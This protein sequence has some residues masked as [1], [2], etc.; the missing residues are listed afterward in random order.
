MQVKDGWG[1][2]WLLLGTVGIV[3][4]VASTYF[5]HIVYTVGLKDRPVG[6]PAR[7]ET[8]MLVGGDKDSDVSDEEGHRP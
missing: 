1:S 6:V 2:V 5:V 4:T 7:G 8:L 3:I